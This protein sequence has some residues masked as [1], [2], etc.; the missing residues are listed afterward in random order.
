[1]KRITAE[2][3]RT[4]VWNPA[5]RQAATIGRVVRNVA[6]NQESLKAVAV[7][8]NSIVLIAAITGLYTESNARALT[9]EGTEGHRGKTLMYP[10][11]LCGLCG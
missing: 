11:E 8:G 9:T 10:V 4:V 3:G 1:M 2:L 7:A 5:G 6:R